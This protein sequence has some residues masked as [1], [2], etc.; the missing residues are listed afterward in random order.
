MKKKIYLYFAYKQ[1]NKYI[2]K[3]Q[4]F[5]N[6]YNHTIHSTIDMALVEV[7]KQNEESARLAT[8]FARKPEKMPN[9]L[10]F[11]FKIG[12]H[13]R[14]THLRNVFTRDYSEKWTGEI[15]TIA[16]RFWRQGQ[17]IYRIKDYNVEEI[18]GSFYQSELQKVSM[19]D[20]DLFKVDKIV[21][22][23]E[24]GPSKQYFIKWLYWTE[25]FASW[26]NARDLH[27]L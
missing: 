17:A 18:Q 14:I 11:R 19:S 8:Y 12:D 16:Q 3:L 9:H 10:R 7:N 1:V 25:K 13:V 15:F 22:T 5:A 27:D 21:K 4:D 6:G 23:R 26:V 24:K 2:D 20:T